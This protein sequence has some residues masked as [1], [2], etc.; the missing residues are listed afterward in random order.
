M[1][2]TEEQMRRITPGFGGAKGLIDVKPDVN[3][4]LDDVDDHTS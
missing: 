1:E 2:V 3:E 4:P